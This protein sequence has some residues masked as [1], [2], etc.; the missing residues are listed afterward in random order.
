MSSLYEGCF[1]ST[2]AHRTNSEV[3]KLLVHVLTCLSLYVYNITLL[4]QWTL[5]RFWYV[6]SLSDTV[7]GPHSAKVFNIQ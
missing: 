6:D 5:L 4:K 7:K 1:A 3:I 2:I